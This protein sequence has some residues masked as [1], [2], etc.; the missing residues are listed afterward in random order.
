VKVSG[1]K[2]KFVEVRKWFDGCDRLK[3]IFKSRKNKITKFSFI[4][5]MIKNYHYKSLSCPRKNIKM[6]KW[7]WHILI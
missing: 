2:V 4:L 5:N 1:F 7:K 6:Y 3:V